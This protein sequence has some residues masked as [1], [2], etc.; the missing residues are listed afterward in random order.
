MGNN[1]V[2]M[3]SFEKNTALPIFGARVFDEAH[4]GKPVIFLYPH[5]VVKGGPT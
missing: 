4:F 3:M 2:M 5:F 1:A